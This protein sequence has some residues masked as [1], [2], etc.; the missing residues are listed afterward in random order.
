MAI[1][2]KLATAPPGGG[3]GK[4]PLP[5]LDVYAARTQLPMAL[6]VYCSKISHGGSQGLI[7][8]LGACEAS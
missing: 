3:G 2:P 8:A 7:A 1:T 6:C 4:V 5:V